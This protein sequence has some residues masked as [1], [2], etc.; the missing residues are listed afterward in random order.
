MYMSIQDA[1]QAMSHRK[2]RNE[3]KILWLDDRASMIDFFDL[4]RSISLDITYHEFDK[5][6]QYRTV[7]HERFDIAIQEFTQILFGAI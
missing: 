3:F 5:G 2:F 1:E 4:A 6:W 7:L